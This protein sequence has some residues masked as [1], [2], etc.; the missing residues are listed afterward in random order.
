[1]LFYGVN[2][3]HANCNVCRKLDDDNKKIFQMI[4]DMFPLFPIIDYIIDGDNSEFEKFNKGYEYYTVDHEIDEKDCVDICILLICYR[5][6]NNITLIR[7]YDDMNPEKLFDLLSMN[8][9]DIDINAMS[10][11]DFIILAYRQHEEKEK[12]IKAINDIKTIHNK[13]I[14]ELKKEIRELKQ[15]ITDQPDGDEFKKLFISRGWSW[16][17]QDKEDIE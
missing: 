13:E 10:E 5:N 2:I 8:E 16:S 3:K 9:Q 17:G 12:A 4:K 6:C 7:S 14:E 1:M 15:H 11:S